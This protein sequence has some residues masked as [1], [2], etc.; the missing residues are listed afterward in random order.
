MSSDIVA[1]CHQ[2]GAPCDTMRNCANTRCHLLFVQCEACK[3]K[4]R[5]TCSDR[6]RHVLEGRAEWQDEYDY[7]RQIRPSKALENA[8]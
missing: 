2:C 7:H 1:R 8:D 3:Q 4:H 6:C 5:E